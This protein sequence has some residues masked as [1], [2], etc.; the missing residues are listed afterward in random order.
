MSPRP[1]P[2]NAN[3]RASLLPRYFGILVVAAAKNE[4]GRSVFAGFINIGRETIPAS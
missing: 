2:S 4:Q 1:D 3:L